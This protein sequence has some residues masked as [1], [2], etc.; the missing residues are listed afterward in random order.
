MTTIIISVLLALGIGGGVMVA[1]SG[2]GSSSGGAVVGP[3]N[4]G[5]G[6]GSGGSGG[7]GGTSGG[8]GSLVAGTLLSGGSSSDITTL[9]FVAKNNTSLE[10]NTLTVGLAPFVP[11][12]QSGTTYNTITN[13][14]NHR[15]KDRYNYAYED[16]KYLKNYGTSS[17]LP[18]SFDLTNRTEES[19]KADFYQGPSQTKALE[20]LNTNYLTSNTIHSNTF[21]NVTW[22][23]SSTLALGGRKFNLNNSDFGYIKWQS[24]LTG[25]PSDL[26]SYYVR[27]GAQA[28]YMF[29]TSKQL[30]ATDYSR[31][32][33]NTAEFRGD[34]IGHHVAHNF[35]CGKTSIGDITGNISLT[36]D[37]T[38][39]T[40]PITGTLTNMKIG[41]ASWYNFGLEGTLNNITAKGT[42][43]AN[44]NITRITY[45]QSQTPSINAGIRFDDYNALMPLNDANFGNGVIVMGNSPSEDELVGQISFVAHQNRA[46]SGGNVYMY[47]N[48]AFGAKKN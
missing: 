11:I 9:G 29:D 28:L 26:H 35:N 46:Q 31:Y 21:T 18:I 42:G 22:N 16:A 39:A 43:N 12:L 14:A 19:P 40:L 2:G 34:V 1:S 6:G 8:S 45:D 4:P 37:F 17:T 48:I 20:T 13:Y 36:I 33:N 23:L 7:G 41:S 3:S 30:L 27:F 44:F 25:I 47:S 32:S 38:N 10:D 15:R 24:S 5:G